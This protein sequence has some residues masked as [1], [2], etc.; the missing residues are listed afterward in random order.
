MDDAGSIQYERASNITKNY[1]L[2]IA[3][4]FNYITFDKG[5][6]NLD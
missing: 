1:L 6:I 3:F 5:Y 4:L 2:F